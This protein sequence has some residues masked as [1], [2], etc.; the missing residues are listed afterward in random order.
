VVADGGPAGWDRGRRQ[1]AGPA[2]GGDHRHRRGLACHPRHP[3]RRLPGRLDLA[4]LG[5]PTARFDRGPAAHRVSEAGVWTGNV[6]F[7]D[8]GVGDRWADLAVASLSLDWNF[9]EGLQQ[10]LF[11]AYG[12]DPDVERIRYY[13]ALW[14]AES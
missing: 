6:D 12:I 2:A 9:G 4:G 10:E 3:H 7:G 1:V 11:D 14:E 8:L 5:R 13:R